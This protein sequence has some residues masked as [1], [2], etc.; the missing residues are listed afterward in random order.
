MTIDSNK[1]ICSIYGEVEA[2][3]RDWQNSPYEWNTEIEI[4][5]EI[6]AR[7]VNMLKESLIQEAKYNVKDER[8]FKRQRYRRV[9]CEPPTNYRDKNGDLCY[10]FPDIV[11]YDDIPNPD[12]PPDF[13]GRMKNWPMLWVCEIK[14][15][16]EFY[17]SC[18]SENKKWDKEKM[19]YL[20]EYDG[21]KTKFACCLYFDRT[22]PNTTNSLIPTE[23]GNFRSYKITLPK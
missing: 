11:V 17:G 16:N 13:I 20:M 9:C 15:Q 23:E 10:G 4:Q 19:R 5:A 7:L 12:S 1:L 22:I 8:F 6:Y 2:F 3:I 18:S 21:G 14:Y